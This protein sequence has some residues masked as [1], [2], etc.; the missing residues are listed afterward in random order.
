MQ[1]GCHFLWTGSD[2]TASD[3]RSLLVSS[4]LERKYPYECNTVCE[5]ASRFIV[6]VKDNGSRIH[7]GDFDISGLGV[8]SRFTEMSESAGVIGGYQNLHSDF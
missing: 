7:S 8:C 6:R 2:M 4:G 3:F 5:L 1:R